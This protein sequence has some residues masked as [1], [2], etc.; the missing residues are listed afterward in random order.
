MGIG[1]RYTLTIDAQ[2][3]Y[4][5]PRVD[6][7]NRGERGTEE[8]AVSGCPAIPS[9]QRAQRSLW[10]QP[11]AALQQNLWVISA[12]DR[13]TVGFLQAWLERSMLG[14]QEAAPAPCLGRSV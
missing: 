12:V 8:L 11:N 9:P 1:L 5:D 3:T 2:I 10:P 14:G 7:T 13:G 4:G 6:Y